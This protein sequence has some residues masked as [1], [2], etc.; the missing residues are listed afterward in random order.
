MLGRELKNRYRIVATL[1]IGGFGQT[2]V[3]EDTQ[4]QTL[5]ARHP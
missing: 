5:N 3:A 1:R 4:R 2:Y